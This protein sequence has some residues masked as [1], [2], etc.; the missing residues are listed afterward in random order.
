MNEREAPKCPRCGSGSPISEIAGAG[1]RC[2][3]CG[4]QW[5]LVRDVIG[6]SAR[7]RKQ[8]GFRGNWGLQK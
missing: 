1:L 6:E 5:A 7:R 2:G 3:Q 4:H 8:E